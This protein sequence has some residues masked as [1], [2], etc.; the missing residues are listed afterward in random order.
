MT[1]RELW[2]L[3]A[4][5]TALAL[6]F[7]LVMTGCPTEAS[8]DIGW[9]ASADDLG[10]TTAIVFSFNEPVALTAEDITVIAPGGAGWIMIAEELEGGDAENGD[11]RTVW[12][13]PI[14]AMRDGTLTVAINRSGVSQRSRT[15]P[16][17]TTA[18]GLVPFAAASNDVAIPSPGAGAATPTRGTTAINFAFGGTTAVGT[19]AGVYGL[20]EENITITDMSGSVEVVAGSLTGSGRYW[21]LDVVALRTGSVRVAI[22]MPGV[23][24][25]SVAV[26]VSPV[27]WNIGFDARE[28]Q[29]LFGFGMP[30]PGLVAANIEIT[31]LQGVV[32]ANGLVPLNGD[33]TG[34]YWAMPLDI[35][36]AGAIE[37]AIS[38]PGV[39]RTASDGAGFLP[40]GSAVN[41][42]LITWAAP[43]WVGTQSA[44]RFTFMAPVVPPSGGAAVSTPM[45]V[46]DLLLAE[47]NIGDGTG[48][49][50]AVGIFG[51][52]N[53]WYVVLNVI[54]DGTVAVS[55]DREGILLGGT[56]IPVPVLVSVSRNSIAVTNTTPPT[57][58]WAAP[59]F[60]ADTGR[61][62][63]V[64]SRNIDSLSASDIVFVDGPATGLSA[65]NNGSV[66]V[67][68]EPTGAGQFWSVPVTVVR[69]GTV[70]MWIDNSQFSD[71]PATIAGLEFN[72]PVGDVVHFSRTE[73]RLAI[74]FTRPL[75]T[76]LT[77]DDIE[78]VTST[79]IVYEGTAP[80][81]TG[82]GRHWVVNLDFDPLP[83]YAPRI[84]FTHPEVTS[85]SAEVEGASLIPWTL[86][87]TL[88]PGGST[89]AIVFDFAS[90]QVD[91]TRADIVLVSDTATV[92]VDTTV[93]TNGLIGGGSRWSLVLSD[94][95]T[96]GLATGAGT[97]N[98]W[99]SLNKS[100]VAPAPTGGVAG[101]GTDG[102]GPA[103]S[104]PTGTGRAGLSV[105][106][107]LTSWTATVSNINSVTQAIVFDFSRPV[108]L[109]ADYITLVNGT[110]TVTPNWAG[111]YGGGR[112][113]TLP[114][115]VNTLPTAGTG[116]VII[117]ID[118]EGV[119]TQT[120]LTLG[121]IMDGA[122]VI[123][124]NVNPIV[125]NGVTT[126]LR[127][128]FTQPVSNLT[129]TG[130]NP[131]VVVRAGTATATAGAITGS[132]RLWTLPLTG[133]TLSTQTGE[134]S[135]II[136]TI[137]RDG[138]SPVATG[139]APDGLTRVTVVNAP[140]VINWTVSVD[141]SFFTN[142]ILIVFEEPVLNVGANV[143]ASHSWTTMPGGAITTTPMPTEQMTA[144][145]ATPVD[146]IPGVG[147]RTWSIQILTF[148]FTPVTDTSRWAVVNVSG[149][150]TADGTQVDTAEARF[151][152]GDSVLGAT[153]VRPAP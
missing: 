5:A 136:V 119:Q 21:S 148:P 41:A 9:N 133:V 74:T 1:K 116:N 140:P 146:L 107:G 128:D 88:P 49:A 36:R 120:P 92:T 99:V 31:N 93:G 109:D 30:V 10:N 33:T 12:S 150:A 73:R 149:G 71:A 86:G 37:V 123:T 4:V 113:W 82:S 105:S 84:F 121:D 8:P 78:I 127:F 52:G 131:N 70:R 132:G 32:E 89:T 48:S 80:A 27:L 38:R 79:N 122:P 72:R 151:R 29:L 11:R 108:D 115:T 145:L 96:D 114:I 90:Y 94:V 152:R 50:E 25:I 118:M 66:T 126:A 35:S 39:N 19:T 67:A 77:W 111:L 143:I 42:E 15:I 141:S 130:G 153:V 55:I 129:S 138:I 18:D 101:S 16:V 125:V 14:S 17:G 13:L 147:A 7:A 47:I 45:P 60:D 75:T 51:G 124:W 95:T 76:P 106:A 104:L 98:V 20:T 97:G 100:G 56:A 40:S 139:T 34:S 65:D 23:T 142:N 63:F 57:S 68:G 59:N 91:L 28:G 85:A 103:P 112:L 44:L 117:S 46:E 53:I 69:E 6:A 144:S 87:T 22:D 2:K 61:I 62:N 135:D 3:P 83:G 110:A 24:P 43:D 58:G 137:N 64:V 26:P 102:F 81:V 134:A 54:R